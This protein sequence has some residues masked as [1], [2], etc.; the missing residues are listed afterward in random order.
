MRER[1]FRTRSTYSLA[2]CSHG[3]QTAPIQQTLHQ[4]AL[5]CHNIERLIEHP[6]RASMVDFVRVCY[7]F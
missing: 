5:L 2:G 4:I 3:D 6:E 1:K 7:S